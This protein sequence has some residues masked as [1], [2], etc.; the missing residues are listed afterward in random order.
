M[1]LGCLNVFIDLLLVLALEYREKMC[2]NWSSY[3]KCI[4]ILEK[5]LTAYVFI[6]KACIQ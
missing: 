2:T 5:K 1:H 3:L 6:A 4:H